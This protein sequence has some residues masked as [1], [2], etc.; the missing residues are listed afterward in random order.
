RMSDDIDVVVSGH[1]HTAYNC[2]I[3]T[4][5]VTSA[6]SNGRVITDI[7]LKLQR[8]TG[9]LVSKAAHNIVVSRDVDANAAE[10]ALVSRYRPLA[11]KVGGRVVGGIT[12]TLPRAFN[13]S[14]ESALGDVIADAMLEMAKN[15]PGA[16]GDVAFMNPGGIRADL[17]AAGGA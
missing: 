15:T 9:K 5:L 10:T 2:T 3:G 17:A 1:S 8:G 13:E 12:A 6:S 16:G 11:V 7:D 4:K 14:G